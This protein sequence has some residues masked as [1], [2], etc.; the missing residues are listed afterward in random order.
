MP[1]VC[2]MNATLNYYKFF[3]TKWWPHM[4]LL[5]LQYRNTDLSLNYRK[6]LQNVTMNLHW[7]FTWKGC[8]PE[9][10]LASCWGK[11]FKFVEYKSFR[12]I[13]VQQL[14]LASNWKSNLMTSRDFSK[15]KL[16]IHLFIT[17]YIYSILYKFNKRFRLSE[18]TV[19]HTF[20][21]KIFTDFATIK[22]STHMVIFVATRVN[23]RWCAS[24]RRCSKFRRYTAVYT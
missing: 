12:Q 2:I 13:Q 11:M 24:M 4:P 16:F 3:D 18:K 21:R 9:G 8:F 19:L 14:P 5:S 6:I 7:F 1:Q 22:A 15:S 20:S 17:V 10:V 23:A